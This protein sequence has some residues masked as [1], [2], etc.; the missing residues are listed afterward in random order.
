MKLSFRHILSGLTLSLCLC[1]GRFAEGQGVVN[2]GGA[3]VVK[4]GAFVVIADHYINK[5]DGISDGKVDLDGTI[6]LRRNWVNTAGNEVVTNIGSSP[7]GNVIMDGLT[8]QYIEGTHPTHFE[9]LILRNADKTLR[10]SDCEV[11]GRLTVDAV[12]DLNAEKMIVDNPSPDA[13]T[14]VS[15]YILS[16]TTPDEGYGQIQWNIGDKTLSYQVPFG[17]GLTTGNDLNLVLTT[18]SAGDPA[19]SIAF[20]TYNSGCHNTPYPFFVNDLAWDK[21][22]I[23][24]RYW[25]V[26][27]Q[28]AVFK[29]GVDITF[30]YTD[31]DVDPNCNAGMD[32][33]YLKA[34]RY[35]T[36]MTTWTDMTPDGLDDPA[37]NTLSIK[38]VSPANFFEPWALVEGQVE[39]EMFMPNA[40]TPDDNS[41]NDGFGPVG[42]NLE[43][44]ND[45]DFYVF[46]RWGGKIFHSEDPAVLW[47][48]SV[49][50]EHET[51]QE[52]VYVWMLIYTD[53]Y[54]LEHKS[55]GTVTL[56]GKID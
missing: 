6:I 4:P 19:G 31:Q 22:Y 40:F 5:N 41:V 54:G 28:Y 25:S 7:M 12:L 49:D 1:T 33:S 23:A 34:A 43:T 45:Y 32:E 17:S 10:V 13:I 37:T 21:E 15:K 38:N 16:E 26:S 39:W 27:P 47:N 44:F 46:D 51:C 36:M 53:H 48:G 50:N 55:H 20:A 29:P 30:R 14:Y 18:T 2:N 52:G 56:I 8:P 11:N 24:D 3:I 9:N 42:F 35:N